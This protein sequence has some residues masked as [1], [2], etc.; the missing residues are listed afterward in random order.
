[1][2]LTIKRNTKASKKL[3]SCPLNS[4]AFHSI[5]D[6][7]F[8]QGS[9]AY[10]RSLMLDTVLDFSHH[11]RSDVSEK[12]EVQDLVHQVP[13]YTIAL[14]SFSDLSER[15]FHDFFLEIACVFALTRCIINTQNSRQGHSLRRLGREMSEL[16]WTENIPDSKNHSFLEQLWIVIDK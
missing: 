2:I 4:G 6:R 11:R 10:S 8:E 16:D 14:D 12:P 7:W 1:M 15:M 5:R 3:K 13:L 9:S